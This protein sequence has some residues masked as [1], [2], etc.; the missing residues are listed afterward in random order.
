LLRLAVERQ[1]GVAAGGGVRGGGGS[2]ERRQVHG[3]GGGARGGVAQLAA[4]ELGEEA[5]ALGLR[6]RARG[7][8][9]LGEALRGRPV[10]VRLVAREDV[11]GRLRAGVR[12][13]QLAGLRHRVLERLD[14]LLLRRLGEL[15]ELVAVL[16]GEGAVVPDLRRER[17]LL[18]R[19]G[20]AGV[21][22]AD[23]VE[24]AD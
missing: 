23:L 17:R 20:E 7:E 1:V 13:A 6:G 10:L 15:R 19:A 14:G 8:R 12:D 18:E 22:E 3:G 2:A 9:D 4:L 16:L 24:R 5:V 11:G 21:P